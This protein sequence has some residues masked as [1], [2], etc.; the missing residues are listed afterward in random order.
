MERELVA[1]RAANAI[2]QEQVT[3]IPTTVADATRG[4]RATAVDT[5][6]LGRPET[7]DGTVPKWRDWKVVLRSYTAACHTGLAGLME[8]AEDTEEPVLNAVQESAGD[9]EASEQLAFILV[10]VCR[11]AALDQVVNAG[12]GEGLA[13]WRSLCRRFEPRIRTRYAGVLLGLLNFDFGGDLIA[14]MEAF[15]RELVQYERTSGETI[16]DGVRIGVVLQRLEESALNQHLLL[17]TERLTRWADFR[18][19]LI[20]VRRA[21]QIVSSTATPMDVG[22]LNAKGGKGKGKAKSKGGADIVCHNCGRKGN[23]ARECWRPKETAG[24][25][26]MGKGDGPRG[27]GKG[28]GQEK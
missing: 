5:R 6:G 27:K 10:M 26:G 23:M 1:Q 12:P 14:R 24:G 21:Q 19:E 8:K 11:G 18:A 4:K 22:A 15:E 2:L 28:K 17:N 20:N 16:S 9:K 7:F 25:K 3:A 13:V